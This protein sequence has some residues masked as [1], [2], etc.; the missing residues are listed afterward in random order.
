M[1]GLSD[2]LIVFSIRYYIDLGMLL[3]TQEVSRVE[4]NS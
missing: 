1:K 4:R 3:K 2:I